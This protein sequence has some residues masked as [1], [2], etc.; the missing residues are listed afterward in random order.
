MLPYT[1]STAWDI[2]HKAGS[3][4]RALVMDFAKDKKVLDIDNEYMFG[5]SF[6]VAPVTEKGAKA[7][8]V[9]LPAGKIWYDFWTN[10]QLQGGKQISKETPIDIMPLYVKAG[11]IIPFGPKVQYSSE[12]KWDNL[13]LRVYTGANGEFTLYEDEKDNYNYEKG[14]YSIIPIKWDEQ[15]GTLTIDKRQGKFNGMLNNR[16]FK[17]VIVNGN[18]DKSTKITKKVSYNGEKVIVKL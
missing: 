5:H 13:E 7:Q 6:L 9:Y 12:K 14:T 1:Y 18:K 17:I 15:T 10:E 8:L 4:I 11:S 16:K 2:T 3:F